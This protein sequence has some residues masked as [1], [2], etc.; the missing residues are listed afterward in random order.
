MLSSWEI[1]LLDYP[2]WRSVIL[3]NYFD[4][5]RIRISFGN[6]NGPLQKHRHL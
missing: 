1:E 6:K 4:S 3:N 5:M 2:F